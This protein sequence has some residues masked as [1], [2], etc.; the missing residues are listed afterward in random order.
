MKFTCVSKLVVRWGIFVGHTSPPLDSSIFQTA[1]SGHIRLSDLWFSK[2][3]IGLTGVNIPVLFCIDTAPFL[4][5]DPKLNHELHNITNVYPHLGRE[6]GLAQD[7][8][9]CKGGEIVAQSTR[10]GLFLLQEMS[11]NLGA[12]TVAPFEKPKHSKPQLF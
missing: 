4:P 5:K 2:N 10:P 12:K 3:K 7:A 1:T 11:F 6:G 8:Q 9:Q